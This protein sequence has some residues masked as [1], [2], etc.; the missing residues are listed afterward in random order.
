MWYYN[1][2]DLNM[3]KQSQKKKKMQ[4]IP[5]LIIIGFWFFIY[6]WILN[7]QNHL[8]FNNS[9]TII[10]LNIMKQ[11]PCASTHQGLSNHTKSMAWGAPWLISKWHNKPN[12]LNKQTTFLNRWIWSL[13]W[14]IHMLLI[15]VPCLFK[16]SLVN[17]NFFSKVPCWKMEHSKRWFWSF[18]HK[19][20]FSGKKKE[21][22]EKR[23]FL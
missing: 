13:P 20:V 1:L 16:L 11:H 8:I 9:Y 10:R 6:Y 4:K 21:K 12:K 23:N 3:M 15:V 7:D 5:Y 18:L 17:L 22:K 14:K 19:I 2:W